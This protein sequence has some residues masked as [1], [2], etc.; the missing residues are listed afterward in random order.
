MYQHLFGPVPSRRLGMS[1]GVDLVPHKVC[2]LNC[3]Y[4]ECGRTTDLTLERKDYVSCDAVTKELNHY[5][6]NH[7]APD[8]ITFSGAGEPTLNAGIGRVLEYIKQH[9]AGIPAAVLTNGTLFWQEAVRAELLT[10]DRVLPSLDAATNKVFQKIN[11]PVHGL[12]VEQIIEGLETFRKRYS[13]KI[14]L[15]VFIAPGVNDGETELA[16]LKKAIR[17]IQPD[18]VQLNTLDRPGTIDDL[19]A[20]SGEALERI[21]DFWGLDNVIIIAS[22]PDRKTCQAFRSDIET[23]ILETISRRPCTLED[24]SGILGLHINEINKYLA[25]LE[26][27]NKISSV[28]QQRGMFYKTTSA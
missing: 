26:S 21:I 6:C 23:A 8:H 2:T 1:L 13:G 24:L 10:A 14:W 27:E 7:P 20:A 25:V 3:I 22:A 15:E 19:Q 11:R 12:D 5:L 4:C 28:M 17:R 9:H 16:R 18:L